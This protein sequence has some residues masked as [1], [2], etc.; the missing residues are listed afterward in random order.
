MNAWA[1]WLKVGYDGAVKEGANAPAEALKLGTNS[2]EVAD[3]A[4]AVAFIVL[5]YKWKQS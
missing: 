4:E 3:Q 5:L 2:F 1:F